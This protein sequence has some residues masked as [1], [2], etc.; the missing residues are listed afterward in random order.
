MVNRL[1]KHQSIFPAWRTEREKA[2]SWIAQRFLA[3]AVLA[4]AVMATEG[5]AAGPAGLPL[6]GA[7]KVEKQIVPLGKAAQIALPPL[8]A[9][10]GKVVVLRFR[11]AAVA[12]REAGCNYN[13]AVRLNESDLGRYTSGGEERLIGREPMFE[14]KD[15]KSVRTFPVF[16]G[17]QLMLMF[18]PDANRAD[19][20][21]TDG[22]GATFLL[23]VSDAARG[24]DGNT[25]ALR[26]TR[27]APGG[28]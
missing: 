15:D 13:M 7:V 25:L 12:A 28:G 24:V 26:N 1:S 2:M 18:A 17:P 8:P 6:E 11:A 10:A 5:G 16:T 22:L 23:D 14:L 9:K 21:A 27:Q 19:A 20:M 4:L 3:G